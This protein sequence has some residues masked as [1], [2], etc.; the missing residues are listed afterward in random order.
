MSPV[1]MYWEN[2]QIL[3]LVNLTSE[4]EYKIEIIPVN[5]ERNS[6]AISVKYNTTKF[7]NDSIIHLIIGYT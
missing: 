4:T 3:K 6:E 5:K 7:G 1:M 2:I